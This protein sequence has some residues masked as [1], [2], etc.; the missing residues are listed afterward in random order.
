VACAIRPEPG[1]APSAA[2]LKAHCR[3]RLAPQK[4]PVV[5]SLVEAF[6]LTGSGKIRKFELARMQD[7]GEL[8]ALE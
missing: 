1:A 4:S 6:P 7:D 3:D 5:W 2:A 8:K